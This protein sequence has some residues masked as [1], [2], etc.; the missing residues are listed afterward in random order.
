MFL[1][2]FDTYVT[3]LPFLGV[4]LPAELSVR[5]P[6]ARGPPEPQDDGAEH[7]ERDIVGGEPRQAAVKAVKFAQKQ[8][9]KDTFDTI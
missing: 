5:A 1:S 7:D 6:R 2:A 9:T 8:S 4:P 3:V